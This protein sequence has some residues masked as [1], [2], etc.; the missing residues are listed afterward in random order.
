MTT[1]L[2]P[3][4]KDSPRPSGP[5]VRQSGDHRGLI[6]VGVDGS[7]ESKDALRWAAGEAQM[8]GASLRVVICWQLPVVPYGVWAAYDAGQES[9]DIVDEEVHQVLGFVADDYVIT[10][11]VEGEPRLTL[12]EA[13]KDADLLVVGTR[14]HGLF[15][16]LLLGSVS[17]YCVKHAR[18]PVAVVH[19]GQQRPDDSGRTGLEAV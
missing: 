12:L 7:E 16:G 2:V 19:H 8:R 13:A 9:K 3:R 17:Q 14:G 4:T 11:V 6:V 1:T 15:A 18:C 5:S 10:S